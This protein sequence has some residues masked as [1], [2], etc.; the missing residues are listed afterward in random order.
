MMLGLALVFILVVILITYQLVGSA[1]HWRQV[2]DDFY[3]NGNY[4]E[5]NKAY[6]RSLELNPNDMHVWNRKGVALS[7]LN[8]NDEALYA[9]TKAI[10][11]SPNDK[12]LWHNKY[13]ELIV[14]DRDEEASVALA[15]AKELGWQD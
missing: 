3:D 10:E 12:I 11:L 5:A 13:N 9:D 1:A 2:G 6:D 14:L 4:E 15:K 7:Y 8:R